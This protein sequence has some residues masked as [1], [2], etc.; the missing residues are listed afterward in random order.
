MCF[1]K[2]DPLAIVAK[3]RYIARSAALAQLVRAPDCGS[4]GPWFETRRWYHSPYFVDVLVRRVAVECVVQLSAHAILE[5][6]G[7]RTKY[8]LYINSQYGVFFVPKVSR[9]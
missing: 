4:G 9:A 7:C 5:Y 8:C 6:W 2:R 3:P 1:G